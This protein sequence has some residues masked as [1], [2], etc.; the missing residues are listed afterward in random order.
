MSLTA[1]D[2]AGV[3][4]RLGMP[5][6]TKA[7]V[8]LDLIGRQ[9][10]QPVPAAPTVVPAAP[11]VVSPELPNYAPFNFLG[12]PGPER[13]IRLVALKHGYRYYDILGSG[14][15]KPLTAARREAV[16]L[17]KSHCREMSSVQIGRLFHRD[18]SSILNLLGR[19]RR[20]PSGESS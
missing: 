9:K 18:H 3:R 13:I 15:T 12:R 20:K 6:T 8:R 5:L 16:R 17:V 19:S 10:P 2:Y 4:A 1:I 14:R 7:K 11:T